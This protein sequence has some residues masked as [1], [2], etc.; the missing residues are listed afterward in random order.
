MAGGWRA[1]VALGRHPGGVAA[2]KERGKI[3]RG[4]RGSHPLP[5]L[6]L[7]RSEEGYPRRRAEV[8]QRSSGGGAA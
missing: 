6:G 8:G 2:V 4:P 1:A 3:E 7:G 5:Q